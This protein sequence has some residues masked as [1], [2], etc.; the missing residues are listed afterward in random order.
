MRTV[1]RVLVL[2]VLFTGYALPALLHVALH[3]LL[4]PL[5]ILVG[6]DDE[7]ERR[8]ANAGGDD[9]GDAEGEGAGGEGHSELSS[10]ADALLRR[11]ERSLQRRR[12]GRRILW[13]LAVW[14]LLLPLGLVMC[15]WSA[16]RVVR[17]W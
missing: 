15:V 4:P 10:D 9:A 16:G 11:K 6:V 13:D 7:T 3:M 8:A 1:Q 2:C 17:A 12:L 5:A 14:V